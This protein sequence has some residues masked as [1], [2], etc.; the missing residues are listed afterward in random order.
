MLLNVWRR[1][2][3]H[4]ALCDITLA[5]NIKS[6]VSTVAVKLLLYTSGNFIRETRSVQ[7]TGVR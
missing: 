5:R 6:K 4:S 2:D 1:A 7:H 3:K